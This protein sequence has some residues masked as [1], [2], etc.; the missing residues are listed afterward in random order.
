[1][2]DS[3][4]VSPDMK[5]MNLSLAS[6]P[7][8]SGSILK[9]AFPATSFSGSRIGS[10]I[11]TVQQRFDTSR[12]KLHQ[13]SL[14]LKKERDPKQKQSMAKIWHRQQFEVDPAVELVHSDEVGWIN[15]PGRAH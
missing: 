13:L 6:I 4:N 9:Q 10:D 12:R 8:N 2:E 11:L 7:P 15:S 14:V 3:S 1:M 5:D